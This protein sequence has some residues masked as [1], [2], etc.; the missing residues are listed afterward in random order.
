MNILNKTT[1]GLLLLISLPSSKASTNPADTE[2][3]HKMKSHLITH[4]LVIV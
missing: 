4:T 1:L 2:R 3:M